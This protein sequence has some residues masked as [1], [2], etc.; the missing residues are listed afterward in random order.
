MAVNHRDAEYS[1]E[2][3]Q[4]LLQQERIAQRTTLSLSS[5]NISYEAVEVFGGFLRETPCRLQ[6]THL[7]FL[8]RRQFR[9]L[10]ESLHTNRSVKELCI[11]GLQD[12]E[13]ALWIA[14]LLR[15]KTD[16]MDI[17]FYHCC[18][19][20]TQIFP[21]LHGQS[22]LKDPALY[23]C[24]INTD[25]LFLFHDPETAQLFVD[26][27]LP[28]STLEKL[29]ITDCGDITENRPL[30]T[31]IH[32][33]TSI[34]RLLFDGHAFLTT[35]TKRY[36]CLGHVHVMLG[37]RT[38]TTLPGAATVGDVIVVPTIPPPCGLWPTVLA[39]VGQGNQGATLVFTIL[40]DRLATWMAP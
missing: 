26:N 19:P 17:G 6:A 13:A 23:S 38:T 9:R 8:P 40:R 30:M 7:L 2:C 1:V 21:Q 11:Q 18:F 36:I 33:N 39:T 16:F 3:L 29:W 10:L 5:D 28:S 22:N 32:Q 37:T 20:F 27:I 31:V 14:D 24:R 4:V 25:E 12:N 34:V 15:H 35:I